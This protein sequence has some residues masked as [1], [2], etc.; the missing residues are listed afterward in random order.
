M[1]TIQSAYNI[2]AIFYAFSSAIL[3]FLLIPAICYQLIIARYE[4][5]TIVSDT[6]FTY[7]GTI[8]KYRAIYDLI[9]KHDQNERYASVLF[10]GFLISHVTHCYNSQCPI[11][12]Y[13]AKGFN[14]STIVL[15]YSKQL[16]LMH[17]FVFAIYSNCMTRCSQN[18]KHT[19]TILIGQA[20]IQTNSRTLYIVKLLSKMKSKV[21]TYHRY[22]IYKAM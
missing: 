5:S 1:Y 18:E 10:K 22:L 2:L 4:L 17:D 12:D 15:D 11:K 14:L 19:L 21:G 20:M 16:K 3:V 9:N 13:F 6:A 8:L 7:T